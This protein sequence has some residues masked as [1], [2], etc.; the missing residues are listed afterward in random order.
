MLGRHVRCVSLFSVA[1]L[2]A[3]RAE[4]RRSYSSIR[5]WHRGPAELAGCRGVIGPVP[6]PLW[7]SALSGKYSRPRRE[8]KDVP[9]GTISSQ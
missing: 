1:L 9:W 4:D 8:I 7:M 2:R 5:H 6:Q 3:L